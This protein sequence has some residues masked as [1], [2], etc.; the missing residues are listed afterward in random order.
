M[1]TA[2]PTTNR[3]GGMLSLTVDGNLYEARGNFRVTPGTVKREGVAGQDRVHGYTETP[4]V[5]QIQGDISIGNQLSLEQLEQITDSTIQVQLANG[6]TY[7]LVQGW[8]KSAFEIDTVE[9]KFECVFQG[10]TCE[11]MPSQ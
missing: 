2:G 5:P 8:T 1:A 10:I 3:I 4:I 9:G 11:E 6:V 7:V